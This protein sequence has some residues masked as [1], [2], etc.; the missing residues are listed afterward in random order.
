MIDQGL[1]KERFGI[2]YLRP[3][4]ELIIDYILSRSSGRLLAVL[5]TGGGKSLCFMYPLAATGKKALLLYPLKSLMHDQKRRFDQAGIPSVVLEGGLER[6]ERAERL[7]RASEPGVSVITNIEM[8][9]YLSESSQSG[10]LRHVPVAVID[11]AHTVTAWGESFRP[12][13]LK[14]GSLVEEIE[15]AFLLAFTA[16]ADKETGE[17]IIRLI[18]GGEEPYIVHASSDRE[19]L[20]YHSV[21]SLSKDKDLIKLL[22]PPQS[23]PALVFCRSRQLSER[24]GKDLSKTFEARFYHAGLPLDEKRLV[25]EWFMASRIGV[26]AATTAYGMGVDKKDIR[27][28]I[29]YNLPEE[30]SAFLQE[31]GRGGRDGK[32]TDSW[33]LWHSDEESPLSSVFKGKGCLRGSLLSLMGEEREEER[34]LA[35]SSCVEDGYVPEGLPEIARFL[36]RHP[37]IRRSKLPEALFGPMRGWELEELRKASS[38]LE[39]YGFIRVL[40]QRCFPRRKIC[41]N[42]S[43]IKGATK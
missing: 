22:K 10:F 12:V 19:N 17:G 39:D 7:R 41:Y 30:A 40:G 8:L 21:H 36:L 5:P 15:P 26:L 25:E 34:C 38:E 2:S 9:L 3:Y 14:L 31:A 35:C 11:E 20:F 29:H 37:G 33:V 23:R 6:K 1:L 24:L 42:Y 43:N 4:Q 27:T 28:V 18:F 13:F 16:T 32:A